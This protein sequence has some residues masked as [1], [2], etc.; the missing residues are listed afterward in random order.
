M[1]EQSEITDAPKVDIAHL[2]R[3]TGG[4]EALMSEVLGLFREQGTVWQRLLSPDNET[5]DWLIGAHTIK[6]SAR[7]IGAWELGEI[8]SRAEVAALE[9]PLSRDEKY[10]WREQIISAFDEAI[11]EIAALEH[12]LLMKTLQS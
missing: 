6:G 10:I 12:K 1:Q 4:D 8:C 5:G 9:K 11:I 2:E 7:S 3:M